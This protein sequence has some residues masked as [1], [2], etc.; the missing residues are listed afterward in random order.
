MLLLGI[1]LV[2]LSILLYSYDAG[3]FISS[4]LF[5]IGLGMAN[6]GLKKKDE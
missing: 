6:E 2:L 3:V 4:V 5:V 1:V